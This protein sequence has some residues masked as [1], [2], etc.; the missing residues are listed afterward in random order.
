MSAPLSGSFS[1][2]GGWLPIGGDGSIATATGL[3]FIPNPG[4]ATGQFAITAN[5]GTGAFSSLT[6]GTLG[7]VKD[8]VFTSFS[9]PVTDFVTIGG[10]SLDL[11][12][13]S[14]VLQDSHFLLLDGS[15]DVT[16]PGIAAQ[17]ATFLLSAQGVGS[18][19]TFSWSGT[20]G[21]E[22]SNG[23]PPTDVPEP[24]SLALLGVGLVGYGVAR[25]RET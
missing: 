18:P 15:V 22:A 24:M 4:V 5:G 19:A 13:V 11:E 17:E 6:T 8:V 3:D 21:F 16:G 7:T 14:V 9:A 10:F 25:R 12:T 23:T 1:M 2:A 20:V